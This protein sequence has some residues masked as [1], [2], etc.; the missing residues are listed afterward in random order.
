VRPSSLFVPVLLIPLLAAGCVSKTTFQQ[1][2]DKSDQLSA[3]VKDLD[4]R[5]QQLAK[6][7][8]KLEGD[9]DALNRR[10][11]DVLNANS[12][13]QQDLLKSRADN[14]QLQQVLSAHDQ[15]ATKALAELHKNVDQLTGQNTDLTQQLETAQIARAARIAHMKSTYNELV[16]QMDA[17]IKQGEVTISD[18][19]GK[20]T[21]DMVERILFDSGKAEI[22]PEGLKVLRKVG[23]IL[24]KVK[25]K[26]VRVAGYTDNVPISAKLRETFPSNW[27][28]SALRA[29]NVVHF[30]QDQVGIPGD[31]LAACGYGPYHPVASNDSAAGRAQ[32]RRIQ[33]EL[34]PL[35]ANIVKPLA[36]P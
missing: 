16:K 31:R 34:A 5:N 19:K 18:L 6:H 36:A 27:E 28:L 9:N 30:L 10:L 3:S 2:V 4:S 8:T 29:I 15:N 7:I 35:D 22:K 24:K 26:G 1:Q 11:T 25:D 23:E 14:D 12:G 32:N 21:V 17:E 13:L 33:I 20:L